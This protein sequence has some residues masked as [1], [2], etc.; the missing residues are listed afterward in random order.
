M[1]DLAAARQFVYREARLLDRLALDACVGDGSPEAVLLALRAYQNRDGGFGNALEPDTRTSS[2]QPLY[3][4][5]ALEY[6]DEAGSFDAES[7]RLACDWLESVLGPE[8][9][10]PILIDTFRD[11]DFAPHWADNPPTP[12]INPNGGIAGLL[13]KAGVRHPVLDRLDDFCWRSL[14]AI[15][16]AHD[17]SE[18]L[19]FLEHSPD[20]RRAEERAESLVRQLPD[21]RMFKS[22]PASSEYGLD[23]LFYARTPR[24][25][26]AQWLEPALIRA[27]LSHLEQAQQDDGGWAINWTPP[28]SAAVAEWRGLVTVRAVRVLR[29][30]GRL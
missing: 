3:F 26:A 7:V 22:D 18:A 25:W 19:A 24:A 14:A 21:T 29:A 12:G 6:M 5:V 9:G 1:A 16:G 30:Y 27:A 13:W 11:A 28:G 4:E 15:N 17:V 2:S 8:G 10:A 23:A 20:R